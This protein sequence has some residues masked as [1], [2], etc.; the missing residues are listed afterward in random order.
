MPGDHRPPKV[1][2]SVRASIP[3]RASK[4]GLERKLIALEL[5]AAREAE[6][7]DVRGLALR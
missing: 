3:R 2:W 1:K 6:R 4:R 7:R 5:C